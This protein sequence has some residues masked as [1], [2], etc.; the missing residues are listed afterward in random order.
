MT[1]TRLHSCLCSETETENQIKLHHTGVGRPTDGA[2]F[3]L[4]VVVI[5]VVVLVC[6]AMLVVVVAVGVCLVLCG[7]MIAATR[8]AMLA[9]L[10]LV[11]VVMVV[12][13]RV[14]RGS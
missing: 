9:V 14:R 13:V 1:N 8:P 12:V 5:V 6:V 4:T 7:R 3:W 10:V 11:V 2:A